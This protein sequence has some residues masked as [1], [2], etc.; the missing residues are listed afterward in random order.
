MKMRGEELQLSFI[1]SLQH[2]YFQKDRY[3]IFLEES[4]AFYSLRTIKDIK[5]VN[6]G[7]E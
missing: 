2:P 5:E 1:D 3:S 7:W 4:P 6:D